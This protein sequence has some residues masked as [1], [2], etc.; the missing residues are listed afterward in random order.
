[1]IRAVVYNKSEIA[2]RRV[3]IV[4]R[5]TKIILCLITTFILLI[6]SGCTYSSDTAYIDFEE[7]DDSQSAEISSA[8]TADGEKP[9]RIAVCPIISQKN[10]IESYR[11]ISSYISKKLGEETTLIER[12][13]YAEINALLANG[14]ADIA[15]L[16]SGAYISYT[17]AEEIEPLATQVR[18]GVPYYY[19]YI[20]VSKDSNVQ[21]LKGLRG[22]TFAFTDPLSFSGYLVPI[23][24]LRQTNEKPESF[25]SN[26][27]YTYSHE[28]ALKAVANKVIDGASIGSH[29][30]YDSKEKKDGLT[31]MVKIVEISEK[32]GI[33]PVVAR[34]A[35]GGNKL[36]KLKDIFLAMHK[37]PE[38]EEAL[39]IL[40]VD[41]YDEFEPD[42]YEYQRN[43]IQE[44]GLKE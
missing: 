25:F 42:L 5:N 35:L 20:I 39:K 21:S 24:M 10:T 11:T 15:F 8:Q 7:K 13:S 2:V 41:R 28:K 33:G 38:L 40:L 32:S 3:L 30:Y 43:I 29:V 23:H 19:S 36:K 34:K 1:M 4:I 22:K 6:M 16:A 27:I 17:G 37:E 18:F 31:D 12:K 14:G 9:L 44:M 26:Y